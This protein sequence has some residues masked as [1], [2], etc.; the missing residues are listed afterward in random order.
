MVAQFEFHSYVYSQHYNLVFIE[1]S[2]T[3]STFSYRSDKSYNE[4]EASSGK[5]CGQQNMIY[6]YESVLRCNLKMTVKAAAPCAVA[7]ALKDF[8][9]L[10]SENK[11]FDD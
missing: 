2:F 4:S 9:G 3:Y 7:V 6:D 10:A 11:V 1:F 8:G 5:S